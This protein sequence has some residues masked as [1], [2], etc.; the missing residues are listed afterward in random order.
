[1]RIEIIYRPQ[2]TEMYLHKGIV[3]AIK[4]KLINYHLHI[5]IK[6]NHKKLM[7]GLELTGERNRKIY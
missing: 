6:S 1:M 5:K 2:C 4:I 7:T 3:M